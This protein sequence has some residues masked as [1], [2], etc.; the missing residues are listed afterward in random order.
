MRHAQSPASHIEKRDCHLWLEVVW[1]LKLLDHRDRVPGGSDRDRLGG[2]EPPLLHTGCC[3]SQ[4]I[5]NFTVFRAGTR[6]WNG[7]EPVVTLLAHRIPIPIAALRRPRSVGQAGIGDVVKRRVPDRISSDICD[8]I[9][10]VDHVRYVVI[11]GI[12]PAFQGAIRFGSVWTGICNIIERIIRSVLPG[13]DS[14]I[15]RGIG[16]AA[17]PY[18]QH[19]ERQQANEENGASLH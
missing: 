7:S 15:Q 9:R 8:R 13:V 16:R 2:S 10:F 6:L 5:E 18:N 17:T 3:R 4:A 14:T 19:Q 11:R 1:M 12:L